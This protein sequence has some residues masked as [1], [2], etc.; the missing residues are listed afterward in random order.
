M[1][2]K[3]KWQYGSK[4]WFDSDETAW[5]PYWDKDGTAWYSSPSDPLSAL[6]LYLD[7]TLTE[8]SVLSFDTMYIIEPYWDFAFVQ[9]S[10]NGGLNWISLANEYTTD[11]DPN[12]T[13]GPLVDSFPGLTGDSGGRM[14]MDF[15]LTGYSGE[16]I[17]RFRYMTDWDTQ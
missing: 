7:V 5:T 9:I 6:D 14:S 4:L 16:A 11:E 15:D 3:L 1:L 17:I 13:C 10:N 2:S 12:G 8:S